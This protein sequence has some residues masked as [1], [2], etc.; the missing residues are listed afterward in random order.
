MVPGLSLFYLSD[1]TQEK[2]TK[3]KQKTV[4]WHPHPFKELGNL[5]TISR[6]ELQIEAALGISIA[7][8]CWEHPEFVRRPCEL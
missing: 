3:T 5:N 8:R 4:S 2:K 7:I 1:Q 6:E